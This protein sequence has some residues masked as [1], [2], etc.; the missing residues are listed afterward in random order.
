MDKWRNKRFVDK[1]RAGGNDDLNAFLRRHN[2]PEKVI[3]GPAGTA[4]PD[5]IREKYMSRGAVRTLPF[6][7]P[8]LRP[9]H[10]RIA[11]FPRRFHCL[12]IAFSLPFPGLPLPFALPSPP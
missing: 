5:R 1:M 6:L 4:N 11:A 7:R 10:C 8:F 9:C 12:L 2:V 3:K